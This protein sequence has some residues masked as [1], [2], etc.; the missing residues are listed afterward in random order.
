MLFCRGSI[1]LTIYAYKGRG[2]VAERW[3]DDKGEGGGSGYPSKVMTSFMNRPL[4]KSDFEIQKLAFNT[5]VMDYQRGVGWRQLTSLNLFW[6]N[7]LFYSQNKSKRKIHLS[8]KMS[9]VASNEFDFNCKINSLHLSTILGCNSCQ[10]QKFFKKGW[11]NPAIVF[12]W[13]TYYW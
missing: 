7:H 2:G 12:F 3:H 9:A 5:T 4:Q 11:Q 10:Q 6:P 1:L 8:L 13:K